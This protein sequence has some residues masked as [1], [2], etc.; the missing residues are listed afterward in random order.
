MW[1]PGSQ[2]SGERTGFTASGKAKALKAG[3]ILFQ[4]G[5]TEDHVYRVDDGEVGLYVGEALVARLGRESFVGAYAIL[6]EEPQTYTVKGLSSPATYLS[7]YP[8][9]DVRNAFSANPELA[10]V[11][12]K[13]LDIEAAALELTELEAIRDVKL[14]ILK[15]RE[16]IKDRRTRVRSLLGTR[17]K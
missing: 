16:F 4:A 3:E 5:S 17:K 7:A 8:G 11:L 6:G 15:A 10:A 13:S 14:R 2:L 9:L 12:A 1:T